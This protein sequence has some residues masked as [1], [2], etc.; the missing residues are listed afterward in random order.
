MRLGNSDHYK[1]A[2]SDDYHLRS[3]PRQKPFKHFD[4]YCV[5]HNLGWWKTVKDILEEHLGRKIICECELANNIDQK[6]EWIDKPYW[7]QLG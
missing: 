5:K 6:R 3:A 4:E 2:C 1:Y 7:E